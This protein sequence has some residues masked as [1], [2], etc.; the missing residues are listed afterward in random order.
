MCKDDKKKHNTKDNEIKNKKVGDDDMA[1][2]A[3]ADFVKENK[4]TIRAISNKN[5]NYNKN[6]YPTLTKDDN[7]RKET[8]WDTYFEE[9]TKDEQ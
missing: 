1:T 2:T 4:N 9:I 3:F 7:W 6:G 8:E 5:T